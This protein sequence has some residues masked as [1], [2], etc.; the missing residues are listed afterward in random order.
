MHNFIKIWNNS[1]PGKNGMKKILSFIFFFIITWSAYVNALKVEN[2]IEETLKNYSSS[3]LF[4]LIEATPDSGNFKPEFI[5]ALTVALVNQ[6]K[7]DKSFGPQLLSIPLVYENLKKLAP[8][9][10]SLF[11]LRQLTKL[12]SSQIGMYRDTRPRSLLILTTQLSNTT[13]RIYGAGNGALATNIE[14]PEK[15]VAYGLNF[16]QDRLAAISQN[17]NLFVW[18]LINKNESILS[19]YFE[20]KMPETTQLSFA[21]DGRHLLL[22]DKNGD[23]WKIGGFFNFSPHT[24]IALI[25][26]KNNMPDGICLPKFELYRKSKESVIYKKPW[27]LRNTD[28]IN[29]E[30][31]SH[32]PPY[33]SKITLTTAGKGKTVVKLVSP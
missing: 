3:D 24:Y 2:S 19:Q 33:P 12:D 6:T 30:L 10:Q 9:K 17:G 20:T 14:H 22:T 21:K 29:M 23:V 1:C 11:C 8:Y 31:N 32:I 27:I 25:L 15:I 26:L 5:K 13:I 18:N 7:K 16:A 28:D 4:K